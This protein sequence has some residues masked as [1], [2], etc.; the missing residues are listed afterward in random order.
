[1]HSAISW[2]TR[3]GVAANLLMVAILV[4]GIWSLSER[5]TVRDFPEVPDRTVTVTVAYRGSTPAEIEQAILT[6]VEEVLYDIE[7]IEEMDALATSSQGRVVLDFEEGYDLNEKLNEVTNRVSTIQTFPPEAE[8]PQIS[9][10]GSTERV[11]TMVLSGDMTEMDLKHMGEQIRDEISN[12]PQISIANLKAVRPY[13]IAIEISE[14]NLK[15]FGLSFG[16]VTQAIRRSSIELSAGS[17]K[18]DAGRILLRTDQQAYNY[19]DFAG[20]TL[21]VQDDGSKIKV[22]QVATVVDG[23]DETPIIASHNGSRAI[24]IDVFRTGT[25]S[26]LEVGET[27]KDFVEAKQPLL[28]K[29]VT[30]SYWGD[31]SERVRTRLATLTKGAVAGFF[32]VLGVLALFLRPTLAFWVAWGIPIAFSGSFI[33][34]PLLGVTINVVVLLAF[35]ITL[36]IV[37]DDAII[38]GENVFQH[39]QRGSKPLTA[40]IKGTQEVAT[41]VFFGVITTMVAFYPLSLMSGRFGAFFSNIPLVVLPV[42]LF[43]LV[44]SKLILPAHLKH[45]GHLRNKESARNPITRFQ[46][47]F[48]DGL[49]AGIM[50]FYRPF[51][52]WALIN[53]YIS[54]SAFVFLLLLFLGLVAGER[55]GY[56]Q[57]PSVPRDTTTVSL[58]MPAGT[59]FETT[60]EKVS[61]IETM[62]LDLKDEINSQYGEEVI[63]DIFAT[64]GS[65]PFGST[66]PFR[67]EESGVDEIGEVVI[68]IAP[69]DTATA[70]Y[71]SQK[72]ATE[73]RKRVPPIPEAEQ[74]SFSFERG[75]SGGAMTFELIHP[76]IETLREASAELQRHLEGFDGLYDIADSYENANDELQLDLKPE[77]EFLGVTAA[78]LAQ[79]IRAAFFGAEA[80]RLQRDRDEIRV[81]VR[82][83]REDRRS[84]ASLRSMMIRTANGTEV[85]FE[86]VAKVVPGKSIPSIRRIDRKR[87]IQVTADADTN[88]VDVESIEVDILENYLPELIA[89]KYPG[90]EFDVSGRAAEARDNTR[91]MKIGIY[92]VLAVI[93]TLLAI[94]FK[95]YFQPL[96]VMSAIPFGVVGAII[97]HWLMALLFNWNGGS[98]L[99]YQSSIFGMMA[100]SGVVVN[101]SLIMVHFMNARVR[102]GMSLDEAVRLAGVRRF[103]PILLTSLTTFFGLFPLMFDPQPSSSFLIPMAISLGWGIIF[104]TTITL[105]LIPVLVLI[106]NDIKQLI[107]NL[108]NI[109]PKKFEEEDEEEESELLTRA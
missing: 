19:D 26:V 64:T 78:N 16:Q 81:M 94:P 44:E 4:G 85:P 68:E 82:Y 55:I 10:R 28:P 12:M 46:R 21:I 31:S 66:I 15:K 52:N 14:E 106:T 70:N 39:M 71:S 3:N 61:M 6:R 30:L 103:R 72:L 83:P 86:T 73:L 23:F 77:A 65:Q 18:T 84:L 13:E 80:Q 49:Q 27:V 91:E 36:G 34:L 107:F 24:A 87:I 2:F 60:F 43:S 109:D 7:G 50:K 96:I 92:F 33:L 58:R 47:F 102:E 37:V 76:K 53:R 90:M 108:Y 35:I 22:G 42:L 40:A 11:I 88:E 38:T 79:Q 99:L 5:I 63:R 59:N 95:S 104:A 8:R 45:C 67:N 41:P 89:T 101:D 54:I 51:L 100:L 17:I 29:G 98:P 1:M 93:Y 20:I 9:L 25:Q 56:R 32:L 69:S 74:L 75:G 48:A 57:R 97:G 105:V 62:A